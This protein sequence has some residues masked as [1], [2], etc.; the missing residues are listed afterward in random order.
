MLRRICA[1]SGKKLFTASKILCSIGLL[2]AAG[3]MVGPNFQPPQTAVP[4]DWAGVTEQNSDYSIPTTSQPLELVEWWRGFEDDKLTSLIER[5]IQ[6]NLD[7]RQAKARIRQARAARGLAG[8]AFW[9]A[10]NA[11]ADY[12]HS[13]SPGA[14]GAEQDLFQAGADAAWELDIFGGVRRNVEAFDAEVTAA[15]ED[16][17]DLLV[18]LAAEI[19]TNY[20]N[21]RSLQERIRIARR[22]L[23]AQHR[24]LE[25]TRKRFEAGFASGLDVANAKAQA[26]ITEAGIPLLE[27]AASQAI[28]NLSV[29]IGREPS[30]LSI[31]LQVDAPVPPMPPEVPVGLPSELVRRRPDIRGAEARIHA[32]T[33]RIGVATADLFPR[34]SLNG[35]FGF[36]ASDAGSLFNWDSRTWSFG[37]SVRWA[38]FDAGRICWNIEIQRAVEE[39]TLL[40]YEQTVLTALRDVESALVAHAREQEHHRSLEQAVAENRRAVDLAMELYTS[41]QTDFLNVL[42]AQGSLYAAED[43]LAQSDRDLA[44]NLIFLYRSLGGGWES[45]TDQAD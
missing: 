2:L 37:P 8:A 34:F 3:C 11:S 23:E 44:A 35:S 31:E 6:S 27:A 10:A 29:L 30:A 36:S 16:R 19:G 9:P 1:R 17:R 21:L 22:N 41:G 38:I 5:G 39:Q 25:I 26:S 28:H 20:V 45:Q 32:A 4:A 40:A 7:L 18:S 13:R 33:A 24:S 42:T 43:A 14:F 12:R 15:V